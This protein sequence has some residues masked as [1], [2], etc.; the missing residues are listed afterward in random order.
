MRR[1]RLAPELS[2]GERVVLNISRYRANLEEHKSPVSAQ[3]TA[4]AA[5]SGFGCSIQLT[6][7]VIDVGLSTN[8]VERKM[9]EFASTT[10]CP[11]AAVRSN[12]GTT[13]S[14]RSSS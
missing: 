12:V 5:Q 4:A 3:P 14:A 6:K 2:I 11:F 7:N 8:N 10:F 9:S 13:P 1:S